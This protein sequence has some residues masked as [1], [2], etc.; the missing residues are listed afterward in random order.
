MA[1]ILIV[2][3]DLPFLEHIGEVLVQMGHFPNMLS[4][5]EYILARITQEVFDLLLL[6]IHF[7]DANGINLL[8]QI[9]AKP[10]FEHLPVIMVTGDEDATL[11]ESCFE[12][13]ASDYI[14]K[15]V[16]PALL[17]ARIESAI[18]NCQ[19]QKI[20]FEENKKMEQFHGIVLKILDY[21]TEAIVIVD[22]TREIIFLN[23]CAVQLFGYASSQVYGQPITLLLFQE[24]LNSIIRTLKSTMRKSKNIPHSFKIAVKTRDRGTLMQ[25]IDV[26]PLDIE[27]NLTLAFIFHQ[28][29]L[30]IPDDS[31]PV[32]IP[33]NNLH[34]Q[35]KIQKT[36][37]ETVID[38]FSDILGMV[39]NSGKLM[40]EELQDMVTAQN[41]LEE[42]F[43]NNLSTQEIRQNLVNVMNLT[44]EL[45]ETA[46]G[47]SKAEL[48]DASKFWRVHMDNGSLRTKT[49]DRYL[50]VQTLPLRPRWNDVIFTVEYVLS[51][52]SSNIPLCK[53]LERQLLI[54]KS[55]LQSKNSK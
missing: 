28:S 22:E 49:M 20:L 35:F 30:E 7:P 11:M 33:D 45:W 36:R 10:E 8:K 21:A 1:S 43:A 40:L 26:F 44:L 13:N 42:I 41:E 46:T 14:S 53:D 3:D 39:T 25:L 12:A 24:D 54:L 38:G 55:R 6:D 48:A 52:C 16:K 4:R 17:K 47:K 50:N 2:D 29:D 51:V 18:R 5:T 23:Q 34:E 19:S 27:D 31:D 32:V 37:I 9:R 15:P